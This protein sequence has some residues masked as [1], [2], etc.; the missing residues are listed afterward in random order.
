MKNYKYVSY[1]IHFGEKM[2]TRYCI[3]SKK[4]KV[5]VGGFS[6]GFDN[7]NIELIL[8]LPPRYW[9]SACKKLGGNIEEVINNLHPDVK[10][11]FEGRYKKLPK[12]DKLSIEI[13]IS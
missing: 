4:N 8:A 5:N 1:H 9:D 12:E 11:E 13:F 2:V 7:V 3:D 6:R 10:K